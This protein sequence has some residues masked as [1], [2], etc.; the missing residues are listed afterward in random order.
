MPPGVTPFQIRELELH[1][2]VSHWGRD[3]VYLAMLWTLLANVNRKEGSRA[4][5]VEDVMP[6]KLRRET[7][8]RDMRRT[9]RAMGGVA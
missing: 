5:T 9:F 3:R 4:F 2:E 8:W 6:Q 1:R 7:D